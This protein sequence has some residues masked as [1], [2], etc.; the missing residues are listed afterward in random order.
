[1][2]FN[3]KINPGI[4]RGLKFTQNQEKGAKIDAESNF[5]SFFG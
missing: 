4:S 1:M 5:H 2:Q 3:K